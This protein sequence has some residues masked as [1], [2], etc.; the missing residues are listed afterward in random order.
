LLQYERHQTL[1]HYLTN[2]IHL[3]RQEPALYTQDF[4]LDGFEWIDCADNRHSVVSYIRYD[5]DR[6]NYLIV[7]CNFTPQPHAHYRI[8]VPEPGFYRELFN[9]DA[10]EFG[11]SNMGNLGGKWTDEWGYHGR[12]CSLDLCLPPLGVMVFKLDR[13][14]SQGVWQGWLWLWHPLWQPA[15][16]LLMLGALV[17]GARNWWQNRRQ[18]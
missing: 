12:P 8:G 11:G 7:V 10:R 6:S 2:L 4:T 14:K 5:K 18:D 3:Y 1:K 13:Q 16:G 17:T 9:S 15:M